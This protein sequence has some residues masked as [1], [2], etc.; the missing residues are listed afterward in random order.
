M[1]LAVIPSSCESIASTNPLSPEFPQPFSILEMKVCADPKCIFHL[2]TVRSMD[3]F[4][5]IFK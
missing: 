4:A 5:D 1:H 2:E 3:V